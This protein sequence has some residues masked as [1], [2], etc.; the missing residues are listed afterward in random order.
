MG[1]HGEAVN[2]RN[3]DVLHVDILLELSTRLEEGIEG[4]EVELVGKHLRKERRERVKFNLHVRKYS[5]Y[6]DFVYS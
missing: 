2:Q 6:T 5:V 4:L 1:I 3:D